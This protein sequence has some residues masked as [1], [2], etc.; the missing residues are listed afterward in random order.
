MFH[1]RGVLFAVPFLVACSSK[2]SFEDGDGDG[3]SPAEG[4]CWDKVEG[5]EG[6]GLKGSDIGPD[7]E[8]TWYDGFD[9]DCKGDD[10]YDA[11]GDGF[12]PDDYVGLGTTGVEGSGF[13]PG[14]DCWDALEAPAEGLLGG[15]DINPDSAEIWYDGL[16]QDCG[17]EDDYDQ[18]GD[19]FASVLYA[20]DYQ[21][22][23]LV[24]GEALPTTDCEDADPVDGERDGTA[25]TIQPDDIN[26]G[27]AETWYDGID[28]DCG[29]EN[30]FD[31]DGDGQNSASFPDVDGV[32]GADC[33]DGDVD[34]VL[35]LEPRLE[36]LADFLEMSDEEIL[37]AFG[38]SAADVYS[39]AP[40]ALYD[41]LDADCG[42]VGGQDCDGDGD[43]FQSTAA[44]PPTCADWEP[45]AE[46]AREV[47]LY[48]A[49][50]D[51]ALCE[52]DDC[53][54]D[55]ATAYPDP[56]V[57]EVHYNGIDE[58]CDFSTGDGDADGDGFWAIDYATI[59]PDSPLAP[60][61]GEGGDCNDDSAAQNPHPDTVEVWYDGIDQ[62]CGRDDDF[63][64]DGD[65]YVPTE[66]EDS[67]TWYVLG[68]V[69]AD[70]DEP[71]LGGNDCDDTRA[72]VNPAPS[73]NE[74][75]GTTYDDDCD[76]DTNDADAEGC[77]PHFADRDGDGWGKIG[78][79][80][81]YCEN[82]D[83][84][85]IEKDFG[86]DG[87]DCDDASATT[88]PGAA[89]SD[90]GSACM[91]DDDG[92][93]YGDISPPSGVVDGSD[94]DDTRS[95]VNPDPSTN[96]N[97]A[98]S[99]DD[100]CDGDTN[101]RDPDNG[102]TY[103]ADADAD[104]FGDPG[105]PRVYCDPFG[106]YNELDNDDCDD[107]DPL[108]NPSVNENCATS[109]DDDCDGD[110][111]DRD[112]DNSTTYFADRDSDGYGDP[113]DSREYCDPSGV[114]NE[115]DDDDC[116]D[117]R[118]AVNP[119]VNEDC[120]TGY[121]DDC[122]GDTND[123]DPDNSTTYFADR[124]SDG[125]GDPADSREYCDPSGVYNELDDDDCDD[126]RSAV[127]P[128]GTETC[129]T[130]YDDDCDGDDNDLGAVGASTYFADRDS[131]GYGDPADSREYCDPS[132]VYNELDDDDCDDTRALVNP[133]VNENCA[134]S[135]D[136]DCDGDTNDRDPDNSTTYFAD[137]DSDNYG[138][139]SDSREYCNPSGVYNELDDDDC[140]DTR[141]AVSPVG[142]ETCATPY[143]DDCD[144][145]DND[146]GAVGASTW[147]ADAD[148]DGYGNP[149]DSRLFCEAEGIYN[150]LDDDD[151][152]DGNAS[153]Y[154]GAPEACD[155]IDSDCDG[156]LLDGGEPDSDGDSLPDCADD[157]VDGDGFTS[158]VDCDDT[159]SSVY[160]G[161][162][163]TCATSY[164]DDCDGDDND[165]GAVGSSTW[166]A[167][168]DGDG[169]GNPSLS[170][171][172][173]DPKGIY[174][175][176]DNDDCDDGDSSV[177]PGAPEACDL[178]DSDCDDSLL[179][180]G[181]ADTD[182]DG[183]PDCA[184]DDVDGDG[185]TSG[186]DCDDADPDIY[187]GAS[188]TNA[189]E[190]V[191]DDCD[192]TID[193]D[194]VISALA[195]DAVLIFTEAQVNPF[196]VGTENSR[197][198]FEVVNVSGLTLYLDNWVFENCNPSSGS[199][200]SFDVNP[201]DELTVAPGDVVLFCYDRSFMDGVLGGGSCDY[202]YGTAPGVSSDYKS[203]SFRLRNSGLN[204]FAVSVDGEDV[205]TV[206]VS[207]AGFPS[208]GD[209]ANEGQSLMLNGSL[210]GA[211]GLDAINDLASSWSLND[212]TA[213]SYE[214]VSGDDN[215]GTPGQPNPT[216]P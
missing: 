184:D 194:S 166:Y 127:S 200:A 8:E 126:T 121:D 26:P 59:V 212:D 211:S 189:T 132:G 94:C 155:L 207:L 91:K 120:L 31:Q 22:T 56:S 147:Y 10:D 37:S 202:S 149:A 167:D 55:D 199:C 50:C 178:T 110:T 2:W 40:D 102:T 4:D 75:C 51:S 192:G 156:S 151:C 100:D 106:I 135:Y 111:N 112:P 139:P 98:T 176:S 90:S 198:W 144:G 64:Q 137:R 215:I 29:G 196:S 130:P 66:Y 191:D 209:A 61:L 145:D 104:D 133:S 93:D 108:V 67:V 12:V 131:D 72:S 57:E 181:E 159:R 197:E 88:H 83:E 153:I 58:D 18:D 82:R 170:R 140:D 9:Q 33:Y 24:D 95:G 201:A 205:D 41:A 54:D 63:D 113:A 13:L 92:D 65:N 70:I 5:P 122:D 179:D 204:V 79:S 163:E 213:D 119:S 118:A 203:P 17:G 109:Y 161:A 81:C 76:T 42:G 99:Y 71:R 172:Y 86:E 152:D 141:A 143:D 45:D 214:T 62:D 188:D 73:T 174:N 78:D 30:D 180:G 89:P 84:Y 183:L 25:V 27:A 164:D 20:S 44:G 103:Y 6:T 68:A 105:D 173:C 60:G 182:G 85:V 157:D 77:T 154:T 16:D 23:V 190:G 124:D 39:G 35:P 169:Y 34:D 128:A 96:E 115:L 52:N 14:G 185:Y 28:Q 216:V 46:D 136:D 187:P 129:A 116:D 107:D 206:N 175:E 117:S 69:L 168:A 146:E 3:I 38:L 177:Y 87:L 162:T 210:V 32:Y 148:G 19:G 74:D 47:E 208:T 125:Y 150:E 11:D 158:D 171:L 195:S 165:E 48:D 186:D 193:E 53:D 21:P 101:D 97:C 160:P 134:T 114:Y 15:F 123:R 80:V 49:L 7:A 36:E 142:T 1:A 43:G 138:D